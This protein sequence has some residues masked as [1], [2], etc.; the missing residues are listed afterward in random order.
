VKGT[1][2]A[3]GMLFCLLLGTVCLQGTQNRDITLQNTP[4][5]VLPEKSE[6]YALLIGVDRYED[7][8]I[9]PLQGAANDAR[10]VK[11]ALV[12]YAGF[13]ADQV[14]LLTSDQPSLR[15]PTRGN[16][17]RRLSNL[18]AAISQ[19]GLLLFFFAGHGIQQKDQGF[20][21]CS[22][23]QLSGDLAL[24]RET[25][26]NVDSLR[27]YIRETG[28]RQVI[29]ILDAC[30]NEP[31]GRSLADN[32]LGEA[33][34]NALNFDVRNREVEAFVTFYASAIGHRAFEFMEK[35][36]GY[37]SWFLVQGLSGAAAN[38]RGEVTLASL[39]HYLQEQVPKRV[40]LDLGVGREQKPFVNFE[41]YRAE[42]LVLTSV[43]SMARTASP[44]AAPTAEDLLWSRIDKSSEA[45]DFKA[46]LDKFPGGKNADQAAR[47]IADLG[48]A[49]IPSAPPPRTLPVKIVSSPFTFETATLNA[50]GQM[51]A[52]KKLQG[53]GFTQNCSGIPLELVFI[54]GGTFPMGLSQT[55]IA[56]YQQSSGPK[57][58]RLGV[59]SRDAIQGLFRM[60]LPQHLVTVASLYLGKYEITEAQWNA[61]VR[62]AKVRKTLKGRP[63]SPRSERFPVDQVSWEEAQEFCDRLTRFSGRIFRLPSEAEWEY[64]CRAGSMT[65][66]YFGEIFSLEMANCKTPGSEPGRRYSAVLAEVGSRRMANAFGLFDMLGNVQ[67]W[68][69]DEWHNSY[70]G[71]PLDGRAWVNGM[72][73]PP[74]R[75]LRGGA[76]LTESE[77]CRS[78][79]RDFASPDS[80]SEG[81][82]FRVVLEIP[83]H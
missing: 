9:N 43:P 80:S 49:T 74:P 69:L 38:E 34:V 25:A 2:K 42:E 63:V 57:Q 53:R 52:Q 81:I 13:P 47:R 79:E 41:G 50:Q 23:S 8:Q 3:T 75:I 51:I 39:I 18:K 45:K 22:D 46:Y 48:K 11:N 17:L 73:R 72:K 70:Q 32:P 20:L 66:Y 36:Q 33:M 77:R 24:L 28:V 40:L 62:L 15:Q 19:S 65:P 35:K 78:A 64:A 61:V 83:M 68:C 59:N 30:R 1:A 14:F 12:Q 37:F 76:W 5:T 31:G 67:E 56:L 7:P 44:G 58:D 82:G 21:L 27:R 71:A 6:R 29:L 60:M 54:P 16:I 4:Q 26:L 55:E 10:A